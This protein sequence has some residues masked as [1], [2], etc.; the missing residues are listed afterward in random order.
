M[1][2]QTTN[3][4]AQTIL[5][6]VKWIFS[7]KLF[8]CVLGSLL[9]GAIISA[10]LFLIGALLLLPPLTL[11]WRSKVPFLSNKLIKAA[12][13]FVLFV[14]GI[15]TNMNIPKPDGNSL[16]SIK[17]GSNEMDFDDKE[18]IL[19]AYIKKDTTDK[20]LQNIT[21]L[22]RTGEMFD[23]GNYSTVHPHD[24]YIKEKMDTVKN[25][26]IL[27]FDPRFTFDERSTY[28][29]NDA[30]NG[31]LENYII[32]FE[33]DSKGNITSKKTLITYSKAGTVEYENNEVPDYETF[34][35]KKKIET[36][37]LLIEADKRIA[38]EREAYEARKK[39]FE[40][41]CLSSWDGSHTKLKMLTKR[42]M[43]DPDSFDHEETLYK[44]YKDYA[45][46][47]MKFRG[48]NAFNATVVNS[49]TAKVD[50]ED[51]EVLEVEQ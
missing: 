12:I 42:S 14:G 26:K 40:E 39:K 15:A 45:I 37:E 24:G 16:S 5:K 41:K 28:L 51:C 27:Q 50:L 38:K 33:L 1:E 44:L 9:D 19:I 17:K 36:K 47:V 2:Q 13:V 21:K 31:T 48:K 30:K 43:N 6:V 22:G 8:F 49:V 29:K 4:T 23:N 34:I 11:F 32:N 3:S 35:D 46:V 20:S 25:A 10:L 7:V 18:D